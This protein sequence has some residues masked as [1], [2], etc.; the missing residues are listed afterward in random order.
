MY[1]VLGVARGARDEQIKVAFRKLAMACHPDRNGG[2]E[3]AQRR[4]IEIRTA[5]ETL[6]SAEDRARYEDMSTQAH[7]PLGC[8]ARA[9]ATMAASFMLT[10]SSG[11]LLGVWLVG[12][13][14]L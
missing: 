8:M 1:C 5:Y 12:R 2:S 7:N 3:G 10:V 14:L 4:F 13:G 6:R 11:W 9:A